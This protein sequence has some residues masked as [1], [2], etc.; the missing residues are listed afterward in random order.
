MLKAD[1]GLTK[2]I[3]YIYEILHCKYISNE[4]HFSRISEYRYHNYAENE[5]V[6]MGGF[7]SPGSFFMKIKNLI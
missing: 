1:P 3:A 6:E 5:V 7:H 4:L 2:D